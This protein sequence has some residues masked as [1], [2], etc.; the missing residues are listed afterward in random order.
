MAELPLAKDF[1][2]ATKAEWQ[3]LVEEALKGAPFA[4]L[5]SKTYDGIEIEPLYPRAKDASLIESR[6]PGQPWTVMQR[7]DIAD[8]A[9]AN[10]QI[11]EDLA[12]G[13][14]GLSLVFE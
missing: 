3:K 10:K 12:N 1:P 5:R 9:A 14:M 4:T 11:L 7:A 13:A 6:S 8:A 2:L